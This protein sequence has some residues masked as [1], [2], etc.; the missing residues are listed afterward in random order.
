MH[1][2]SRFRRLAAL[3]VV[4]LA[5]TACKDNDDAHEVDVDF[6]RITLGAQTVTVNA[7]GAVTGGTLSLSQGVATNVS[8]AFLNSSMQDALGEHA[9]DF[10]VTIT[11][12]AGITF[13]RTGPFAGTLTGSTAGTV[14]VSFALLHID[15]NH[16]DFGPFP[17]N[18]TVTSPPAV[19]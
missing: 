14:S 9:D 6:M 19:Q 17:V 8:V 10:Q 16:E 11:P 5:L 7:T 4:A 18:I 2:V 1:I 15:E 3:A 13:A 12:G